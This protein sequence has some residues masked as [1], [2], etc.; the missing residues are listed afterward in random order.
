[1]NACEKLRLTKGPLAG[2]PFKL[3][4]WQA[5]II[6]KVFGDVNEAGHRKVR[7]VFMLLPRGSGKTTLTSAIALLCLFG[8]ERDA[9]GQ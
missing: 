3:A 2:R 4:A 6:R 1:L 7:T 9:A 5:R 8:P